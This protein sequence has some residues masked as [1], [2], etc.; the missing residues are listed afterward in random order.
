VRFSGT[1]TFGRV[2]LVKE[3]RLKEYF[4]LKVMKICDIIKL[5]QIQHVKNEKIILS[6]IQHP[7]IV[8][9]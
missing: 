8:Q 1:G 3:R 4:A 6:Q 2:V 7:F 5:K 9:L